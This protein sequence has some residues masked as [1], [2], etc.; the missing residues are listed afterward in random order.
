VKEIS[1]RD[2]LIAFW[3]C[4]SV[5]VALILYVIFI[6]G[7]KSFERFVALLD[8]LG[9]SYGI[10]AMEAIW[11]GSLAVSLA[12]LLWGNHVR[13]MLLRGSP[14]WLGLTGHWLFCLFAGGLGFFLYL[15]NFIFGITSE[16]LVLSILQGGMLSVGFLLMCLT[17][18]LRPLPEPGAKKRKKD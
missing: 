2:K 7:L 18:L 16:A 11:F 12:I 3:L 6:D 5:V 1:S 8:G 9:K 13:A 17:G 14:P 4:F 15:V 10:W